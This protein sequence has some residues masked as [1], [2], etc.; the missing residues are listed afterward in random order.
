MPTA[1]SLFRHA[2]DMWE[3]ATPG[4]PV[5]VEA[6]NRVGNLAHAR[7]ALATA[8]EFHGRA[9][10]VIQQSDPNSLEV[11]A[12][13]LNLGSVATDQGDLTAAAGIFSAH[14]LSMRSTRRAPRSTQ[15]AWKLWE[16]LPSIEA[17]SLKHSVTT[18]APS[19]F[20]KELSP[21]SL[22]VASSLDALAVIARYRGDLETAMRDHRRAL[23][24]RQKLA[25]DSLLVA[26]SLDNVAGVHRLQ[27]DL[28]AANDGYQRA[29]ALFEKQAPQSRNLAICLN[30][31]G[32][33][34][35][36][37]H[38]LAA[39]RDYY[40]R[41]L[42]LRIQLA[43]DFL[44]VATILD[45]LGGVEHDRGDLATALAYHQRALRSSRNRLPTRSMWQPV[46]PMSGMP[47]NQWASWSWPLPC[48]GERSICSSGS[49]PTP[50][51]WPRPLTTWVPLP[52]W[53]A[54]SPR[55]A[56]FTGRRWRSL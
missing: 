55:P 9:L 41:A 2:F 27:G 15:D 4:S 33:L 5:L 25:P 8:A 14:G 50:W 10:A 31:L 32:G 24:L 56:A 52:A 20:A 38:D 29:L 7:G 3:K 6:L 19:P 37:Q 34:A 18:S 28:T 47:Q 54:T 21:V 36:Q 30:N 45:N 44:P 53:A 16:T 39:A 35:R 26:T 48:S 42:A 46:L 17:I 1:E 22:E 43:P 49:S 13:L 40:R 23:A 51:M 11:A 12:C